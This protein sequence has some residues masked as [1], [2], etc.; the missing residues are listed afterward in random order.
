MKLTVLDPGPARACGTCS[1]CCTVMGVSEIAKPR[2]VKCDCLTPLGR[3]G[4]YADRPDSCRQFKCL[5]LQG[6][7]PE[8]LRPERV[9]AVGDV[10]GQGDMIVFHIAPADRGAHRR[11]A[12]RDFIAAVSPKV[13]II[14]VCGEERHIIGKDAANVMAIVQEV[15]HAD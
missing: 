9:R 10:N 15:A 2:N 5:W 8:G 14:V 11:G 12:L 6:A 13:T 1:L 4:I 3:C 7:L